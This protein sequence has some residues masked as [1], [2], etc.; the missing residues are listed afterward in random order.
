VLLVGSDL[1]R[2]LEP[3][4]EGVDLGPLLGELSLQ[5]VD[6]S[7]G[8]GAVDSAGDWFGLAVERLP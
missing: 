3:L 7:L 8:R 6:P 5:L 1:D 2:V 4:S